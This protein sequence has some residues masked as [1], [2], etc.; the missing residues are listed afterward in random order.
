[1]SKRIK[2]LSGG[3]TTTD[4]VIAD[5][6]PLFRKGLRQA[7]EEQPGEWRV[8]EAA[9]GG[10]AIE[11]CKAGP[12]DALILDVSMPGLGGIPTLQRL[13]QK[14]LSVR[15]MLLTMHEEEELIA[16]GMQLGVLAFVL[17]DDAVSDFLRALRLLLEGRHY[18]SPSLFDHFMQNRQ[19]MKALKP[20]IH[21]L[22]HLTTTER[23]IL[24]LIAND[25]TTKEIAE[26]LRSSVHTIN[27][28]RQNLS[29][30]LGLNGTHSLLKFAFDCRQSLLDDGSPPTDLKPG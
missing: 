20:A 24:G 21:D 25:L 7:I 9:D 10:E 27:T 12:V 8:R 26:Q 13:Q 30:K 16:K 19:G 23:K 15:V 17:K 5:D 22:S 11:L 6:H 4:V 28:H 18:L 29:T 14:R 1:M 2:T 3:K